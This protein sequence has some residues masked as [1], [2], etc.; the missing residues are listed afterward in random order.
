MSPED[1]Y[2]QHLRTIER[3]ASF[4][5]HRYHLN[6]DESGEF[7]QEVQLRLIDDDYAII[8][9]F[10]G[11]SQFSTYLTTVILRLFQQWRVEQWGKWRPSAE[12][13]RL[14]EKAVT[15]ERLLTRDGFTYGEAVKEL[16]TPAGSQYTA[17]ELEAIYLRLPLRT[18]RPVLVSEEAAPE[19][20]A[21]DTDADDRVEM[22][23]RERVARDAETAVDR[24]LESMD[25]EDCLI[26]QLRFWGAL[27]AP[28]IAQRLG[29]EQ[30][31]IYKRLDRL[32][33]MLRRALE[34][35]GVGK[36][37]IGTLLCRGDQDIH[38]EFP[39]P[40]GEIRPFGPSQGPGGEDRGS[41][42]GLR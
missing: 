39:A 12:A 32:F 35:A 11:R 21:V 1:T 29:I 6:G 20:A 41:E 40:T 38:F 2:L 23:D 13:R 30:K 28:E 14:G 5:A 18:P 36:A 24:L 31:K 37:E 17:A 9:K 34:E 26:L 4:V 8:R 16:T 22:H 10:E 27:K 25:A 19:I 42:E 15:L 7:T 33:L 3:I